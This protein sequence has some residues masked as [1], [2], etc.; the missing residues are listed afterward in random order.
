MPA[1]TV[2][3]NFAR[4]AYLELSAL[5]HLL[6][7]EEPLSLPARKVESVTPGGASPSPYAAL[8]ESDEE[9]DG[10][11]PRD[12]R[13][14]SRRRAPPSTYTVLPSRWSEETRH[15]SLTVSAEGRELTFHGQS[16]TGDK[17]AASART[18]H[19]A[20]AACGIYYYEVEILN[21]PS[22]GCSTSIGFA[23]P[24]ARLSRLPGSERSSW[25]YHGSD[26][27]CYASEREGSPYGVQFQTGDFIG[28]GIDFTTRR[29]FFT[30]NGSWINDVFDNV[31]K[32]C[33]IYPSVGMRINSESVRVNFGQEAFKYDIEYHVQQK[34]STVWNS[35]LT[36]PISGT[37]VE[38][39]PGEVSEEQSKG[40]I[41][42]LV[43]SYLAHHGY[44][45]TA[46]AFQTQIA[47]ARE[48]IVGDGD[49]EMEGNGED[50]LE[51]EI[52]QRTKV[53]HAVMEGDIDGAIQEAKQ[54]YQ[55][56]LEMDDGLVLFKLKC[57]KFVELVMKSTEMKD[58]MSNGGEEDSMVMDIDDEEDKPIANGYVAAAYE[59]ALTDAISYGQ[60]LH[61]EYKD[62]ARSEVQDVLKRTFGILAFYDPRKAV[63][64]ASEVVGKDARMEL[65][66]EVNRAILKSQGKPSMPI[67]ET[68][69][70]HTAG[71]IVQLGLMG[72]GSAAFA[73]MQREL[74]E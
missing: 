9:S 17:D 34:R 63:G 57:R 7:T 64:S 70:R 31:G 21:K 61:S 48:G 1:P 28:C 30:R 55:D 6:H 50:G 8:S 26:G 39:R 74:L 54:C 2:P 69:Y 72:V 68:V 33:D 65:A 73:D 40:R 10:T 44:A 4:P 45:R 38:G 32:D 71:C 35:I 23:G 53:V 47:R 51:G 27:Y 13:A 43:L 22:K 59:K 60:G 25:G 49:V 62:D 58:K 16:S 20:P 24:D 52:E 3:S 11:P 29:M 18:T 12:V 67:L 19:P 42:R 66:T 15:Q 56:V 5:R 14:T 36:T 41:N 37:I 46:R